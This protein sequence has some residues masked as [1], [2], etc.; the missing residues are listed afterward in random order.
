M[1]FRR[2]DKGS[3]GRELALI[4]EPGGLLVV[5]KPGAVE[6]VVARLVEVG[7]VG[8]RAA[9]S[10]TAADLGAIATTAGALVATHGQYVRLTA[11]S[12][13]LL[14][15][16]HLVPTDTGSFW[17]FVRDSR[18][19]RG[20][21]DFDKVD[22]GPQQMLSLQVAAVSLALRAAI[23]EVEAA[24]ERVEGKVDDILGL[25][26]AQ[27]VGDI[28]GT[29]RALGPLVERVR[30]DGRISSTD[31]SAVATLGADI[32]RDIEALRMHIRSRLEAA[33]GGWRPGERA[34]DA[35][36][37]F[38]KKGLLVESIALLIVAE[39]NLGAWH[40]MRLAHVR[41][42]EPAH[43][44][45]TVEDAHT[46]IASENEDDQAIADAL[47]AVADQLTRPQAFD[48]L[49]PWQRRE[50]TE[51]RSKL[52]ELVSWFADQ[53]VLDLAP[54][55]EAPYPSATESFR[56]IARTVGDVASR[57]LDTVRERVRRRGDPDQRELGPPDEQGSP[58][59][60]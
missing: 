60:M 2:R 53:R 41:V 9:S 30:R 46:A 19:I 23:K 54:L 57:S 26:R 45:W 28:L 8:V 43:L 33:D 14:K 1:A 7:G 47:R 31:W 20:A 44:S 58:G 13:E 3:A 18:R 29:R 4:G 16:H 37:L 59:E 24:V 56:S 40:E 50:L 49:A 17:G 38:E 48:G 32:A 52:D 10:A 11:R 12:M 51:A 21:L 42:N 27:R 36:G 15:Q 35:E 6:S 5:G 22:L 39:H 25:L 55:G 34:K